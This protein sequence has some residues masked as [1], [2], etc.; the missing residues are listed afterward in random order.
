MHTAR[1]FRRA[2]MALASLVASATMSCATNPLPCDDPEILVD[3]SERSA[4]TMICA[5][6]SDARRALGRCGLAQSAPITIETVDGPIQHVGQCLAS[7]DCELGRIRIIDPD[8]LTDYLRPEDAY[9]ALPAD[10][11]FRSLLTHEMAHA[12]VDQQAGDRRIAPVD[13][14]YIANAL[15][16]AALAPV[17]RKTMLDAAGLEPPVSAEAIN[18]FVYGLA[19]RR[20]AAASY[21]YFEAHGCETVLGILSGKV[22]FHVVP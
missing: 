7:F 9:T 17:H 21:L 1:P 19:P 14:E 2:A 5:A 10:V 4:Q 8:L 16:L 18:I 22:S 3:T 13:H 6:A 15:E 11:V 20:F 12:L